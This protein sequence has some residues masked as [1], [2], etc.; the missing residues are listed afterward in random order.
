[1]NRRRIA[2][3]TSAAD[4]RLTDDDRLAFEPLAELGIAVDPL[5]WDDPAALEAEGF[6]GIVI[7]SC[8]DYHLKADAFSRRVEAW[9]RNGV[10]LWNPARVVLW[11]LH[12]RYLLDL[13]ARGARIPRTIVIPRGGDPEAAAELD[14]RARV[15]KPAVSLNGHDTFL[16]GAADDAL[17][18]DEV[19]ELAAAGDVIVQEFVPEVQGGGEVSL[20]FFGGAFSHAIRKRPRAGEFRVQMEYGGSREPFRPA[21]ELVQQAA[22]I[23]A[24]AGETLLYARVDG[25][26]VGGELV[27]MELEVIDPFLYLGYAEGAPQRFA[28]ALRGF[29]SRG[30]TPPP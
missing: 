14:G 24:M 18:R 19:R 30:Y 28:E 22:A 8:W 1:V 12:K 10:R 27:L 23:L 26:E 5:V 6:E 7:R 16:V 29:M 25:V 15:V 9:A 17:A 20:V 4:H 3:A 21:P 11:N 2:F 13:A